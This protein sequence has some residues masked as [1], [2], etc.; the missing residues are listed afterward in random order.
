[1][2]LYDNLRQWRSTVARNRGVAPD[3]VFSN[4]ILLEI[5]KRQPQTE[6]ELQTIPQIGPWKAKTYGPAVLDVLSA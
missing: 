4:D 2:A 5:A 3:L 6:A 1:M